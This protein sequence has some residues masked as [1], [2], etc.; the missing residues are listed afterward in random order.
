MAASDRE[1]KKLKASVRSLQNALAT[2]AA[3]IEQI[4]ASGKT[5]GLEEAKSRIEEIREQIGDVL[6]AQV[7][8]AE[9]MNETV[10]RSVTE[11]PITAVSIAFAVGAL[12]AMILGTRR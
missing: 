12:A 10:R 1:V 11:N 4:G 2:I 9:E 3:D 5:I 7:D 8:R 6:V